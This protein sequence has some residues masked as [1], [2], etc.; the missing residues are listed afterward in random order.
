[1]WILVLLVTGCERVHYDPGM[2]TRTYPHALHQPNSVDIQVFRKGPILEIVNSTATTYRNCDVW[3]NQRFV[4]H[5]GRLGA[6]ETVQLSLW[7]FWD[8]RGDRFSGGGFWRTRPVTPVRL[9]QLQVNDQEPLVGL[10]MIRQ[11]DMRERIAG[12]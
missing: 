8:E 3:I 7:D 4:S 12:R 10:I 2:A 9:V 6:G 11:E 5:L 1:M